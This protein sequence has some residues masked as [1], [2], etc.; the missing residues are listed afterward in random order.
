MNFVRSINWL[1]Q[2]LSIVKFWCRGFL[3]WWHPGV[4]VRW[5]LS[6]YLNVEAV[7]HLVRVCLKNW[8]LELGVFRN[9]YIRILVWVI[10]GEILEYLIWLFNEIQ[11]L[12][13]VRLILISLF[14]HNHRFLN[15]FHFLKNKVKN[16]YYI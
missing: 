5:P 2:N 11:I 7:F 6:L 14:F 10:H 8:T 13:D 4:S 9:S 16:Y 1:V 12:F 15:P 3:R